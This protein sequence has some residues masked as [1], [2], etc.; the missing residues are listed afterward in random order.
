MDA[1]EQATKPA[2]NLDMLTPRERQVL[3]Q[4]AAGRT[5]RQIAVQLGLSPRTVDVYRSHLKMKLRLPSLVGLVRF[6]VEHDAADRESS[7]GRPMEQ[8]TR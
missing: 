8:V 6:A 4:I 3:R 5:T 7:N 2:A 1:I